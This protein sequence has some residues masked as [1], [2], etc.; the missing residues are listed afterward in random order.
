MSLTSGKRLI[1]NR[2]TVLP[3][4]AE[5]IAVVHQL[6]TACKKYKSIVFTDKDGT[7]IDDTNN[8]AD[9]GEYANNTLEIT[10]VDT[11]GVDNE[12]HN[13]TGVGNE[14]Y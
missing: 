13:N 7:I 2:W 10:G 11:T 1:R 14:Q 5:V 12:P 3:M 6:A 4:P 9:T 8:D